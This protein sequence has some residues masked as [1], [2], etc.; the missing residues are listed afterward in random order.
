MGILEHEKAVRAMTGGFCVRG[1]KKH[2]SEGMKR[3]DGGQL[4][5]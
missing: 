1:I 4:F 3:L 5:R 2:R